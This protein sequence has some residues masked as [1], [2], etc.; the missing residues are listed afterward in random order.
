LE[1]TTTLSSEVNMTF[2]E[3]N[4]PECAVESKPKIVFEQFRKF[5][6]VRKRLNIEYCSNL[7]QR[8]H[9]HSIKKTRKQTFDALAEC[10]ISPNQIG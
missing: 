5:L 9:H 8:S 3:E 1:N 6:A 10:S 7:Q 2:R 4:T